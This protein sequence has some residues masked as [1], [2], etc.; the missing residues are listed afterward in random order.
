MDG[1]H[2]DLDRARIKKKFDKSEYI[3][4]IIYSWGTTI[5]EKW[6]CLVVKVMLKRG[7]IVFAHSVDVSAS[8][9]GDKLQ[10]VLTVNEA[11]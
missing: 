1:H 9:V 2:K 7:L 4:I 5:T 6:M 10:K 11:T 8:D 3:K